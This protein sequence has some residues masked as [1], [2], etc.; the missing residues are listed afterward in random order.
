MTDRVITPADEEWP[1]QL[2]ELGP[3]RPPKQLFVR[4]RPL[5][6]GRR[7]VAVVG[8]RRPTA[9]GIEAAETLTRGLVEAGFAIVSGMA[10]GIDAAAHAAAIDAGGYTVA[11]LGCGLDVIYPARNRQLRARIES[12]G[13][14]LTEYPEGTE[15]AAFHFPERNRIV[16]GLAAAVLFVEGGERS[17]GLITARAALDA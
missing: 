13:T 17:G 14:L 10:M 2:D 3:A 5:E 11:V 6:A 8:A 16:A 1:P 12:A 9:A 15:P 7:T 4:G